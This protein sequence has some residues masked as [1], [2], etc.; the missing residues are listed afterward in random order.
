MSARARQHRGTGGGGGGWHSRCSWG[1]RTAGC[2]VSTGRLGPGQ[3]SPAGG[4]AG[5]LLSSI[6]HRLGVSPLRQLAGSLESIVLTNSDLA[7]ESAPRL[8][9]KRFFSFSLLSF[10][11]VFTIFISPSFSSFF[12]SPLSIP[13]FFLISSLIPSSAVLTVERANGGNGE[14]AHRPFSSVGGTRI[15][16]GQQALKHLHVLPCRRPWREL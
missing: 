10:P 16:G 5:H 1:L 9:S 14:T 15:G 8:W 12:V 2:R 11:F 4:R 6:S 7:G 3:L 13:P